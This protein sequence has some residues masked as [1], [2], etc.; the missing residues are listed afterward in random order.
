MAYP[1][2]LIKINHFN[3]NLYPSNHPLYFI[4]KA[5]QSSNPNNLPENPTIVLKLRYIYGS[6]P[7]DIDFNLNGVS[8][9]N[10][11]VINGSGIFLKTTN[12]N[13]LK[14]SI[15]L[16]FKNSGLLDNFDFT[17]SNFIFENEAEITINL[18]SKNT[19]L[20]EFSTNYTFD[21]KN[22]YYELYYKIVVEEQNTT[23][24]NVITLYYA[25]GDNVSEDVLN[26]EQL[27]NIY[28]DDELITSLSKKGFEIADFDI[29]KIVD[30]SIKP[31]T[32]IINNYNINTIKYLEKFKLE[33]YQKFVDRSI[34]SNN[35]YSSIYG[36]PVISEL[37]A[38]K[39]TLPLFE[40]NYNSSKYDNIINQGISG[41]DLTLYPI[42][43]AQPCLEGDNYGFSGYFKILSNQPKYKALNKSYE[44]LCYQVYSIQ[45][46]GSLLND[47][48]RIKFIY[49]NDLNQ[50]QYVYLNS[51]NIHSGE[52]YRYINQFCF[53][54]DYIKTLSTV[55]PFEN[56]S[57]VEITHIAYSYQTER[58]LTDSI[59]ND[60]NS[61]EVEYEI[62]TYY[63]DKSS[64]NQE[65]SNVL[66]LNEPNYTP[67]VFLNSLGG[68][69]LFEFGEIIE[70]KSNRKIE[71][72]TSPY[73]YNT[74]KLDEFEKIYDLNYNDNYMIKS[75]SLDSEQ[76]NWLKDLV[77]SKQVYILKGTDLIPIIINEIT[78]DYKT[79]EDR[80]I[81]M[82][83]NYSKPTN[84]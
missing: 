71:S 56:V 14:D 66:E 47:I 67:I 60:I 76:F 63:I 82:S 72:Y 10:N 57:K 7:L 69:D 73:S 50:F 42:Q 78:Y 30:N 49:N 20:C 44:I 75:P 54:T 40:S 46:Q 61:E 35:S 5:D 8:Y 45:S 51:S 39:T 2:S 58:N 25:I 79:N 81:N 27:L 18:I 48:I 84:I 59:E 32:P 24:I 21:S 83:F 6:L 9:K 15:K 29:S 62:M 52:S 17:T 80:N 3:N 77:I 12:Y 33:A 26:F 41:S 38:I 13:I 43:N 68:F 64:T 28:K 4:T 65:C 34:D 53:N 74:N 36:N 22:V 1:N 37:Y 31:Y 11:T 16:C 23:R 55:Q 70:F 19:G